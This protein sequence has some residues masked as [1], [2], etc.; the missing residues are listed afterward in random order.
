[1]SVENTD[2]NQK[3][4]ELFKGNWIFPPNSDPENHKEFYNKVYDYEGEVEPDFETELDYAYKYYEG[5]IETFSILD[6]K[7]KTLFQFSAV[8]A[9][10]VLTAAKAFNL[11]LSLWFYLPIISFGAGMIFSVRG[12]FSAEM[13]F[14]FNVKGITELRL[15]VDKKYPGQQLSENHLRAMILASIH[16]ACESMAVV[17]SWKAKQNDRTVLSIIIGVFSS[18]IWLWNSPVNPTP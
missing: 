16:T 11:G 10:V 9:G 14:G 8:A 4:L 13:P 3:L 6:S 2:S 5:K 15:D 18:L 1:M 17:S 12:L 7:S